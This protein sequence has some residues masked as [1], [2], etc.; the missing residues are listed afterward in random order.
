VDPNRALSDIREASQA[1]R[2]GAAIDAFRA[3]DVWLTE[4]RGFLPAPWAGRSVEWVSD[5][6]EECEFCAFPES[7]A[8]Y[9]RIGNTLVCRDHIWRGLTSALGRHPRFVKA[10]VPADHPVKVLGPDDKATD[11]VTCESCG[12]S[13]DDAVVTG[14]TPAPAGR[15]PFEYWH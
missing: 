8:V 4:Q 10:E 12:R 14:W 11:R 2:G 13:W 3:L 5:D 1:G 9:L 15:C 7:S 6:T